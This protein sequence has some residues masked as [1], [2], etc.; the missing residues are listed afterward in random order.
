MD[1]TS[2]FRVTRTRTHESIRTLSQKIF[3]NI[4][5]TRY[6]IF[7]NLVGTVMRYDYRDCIDKIWSTSRFDIFLRWLNDDWLSRYE[8]MVMYSLWFFY[9]YNWLHMLI[10]RSYWKKLLNEQIR[11][12]FLIANK[13]MKLR[14]EINRCAKDIPQRIHIH[15]CTTNGRYK[16]KIPQSIEILS[17][18]KKWWEI[19][20][21]NRTVIK[22]T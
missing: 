11:Y 12:W 13:K 21:L 20:T 22:S 15:R 10:L 4:S 16:Y 7:W 6:E 18:F 8:A 14:L 19:F 17:W 5:C 1:F 2:E 9:S 3:M